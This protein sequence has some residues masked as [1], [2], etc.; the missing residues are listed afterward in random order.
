MFK[1]RKLS[2][3]NL[4]KLGLSKVEFQLHKPIVIPGEN[5]EASSMKVRAFVT[6]T[7]F[8]VASLACYADVAVHTRDNSNY[9]QGPNYT[10]GSACSSSYFT[11]NSSA[12]VTCWAFEDSGTDKTAYALVFDSATSDV[13]ITYS[14]MDAG[15]TGFGGVLICTD[16]STIPCLDPSYSL[17][18]LGQDAGNSGASTSLL[19][20]IHSFTP[21]GVDCSSY[22][23]GTD[24]NALVFVA[25]PLEGLDINGDPI[26][27]IPNIELDPLA[28]P[29]VP[30][31][32]SM[33]L[34]AS[35]VVGVIGRLRRK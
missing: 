11:N 2:S 21:T 9:G 18:G 5:L 35:G 34:L 16:F 20:Y 10:S 6:V 33:I 4:W 15:N 29:T 27:Y 13:Q 23:A 7:I 25:E 24:C 3:L 26:D 1:E 22:E 17:S 28:S 19:F 12:S 14:G 32:S 30:E 31:P 8:L